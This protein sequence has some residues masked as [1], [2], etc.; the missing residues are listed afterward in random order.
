MRIYI[1]SITVDLIIF[2]KFIGWSSRSTSGRLLYIYNKYFTSLKIQFFK[3]IE[4]I[5][6]KL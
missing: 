6:M 1:F 5:G 4:I 2:Y 3:R